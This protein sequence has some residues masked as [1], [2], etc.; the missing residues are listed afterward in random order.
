MMNTLSPGTACAPCK[1]SRV[2]EVIEHEHLPSARVDTSF[3]RAGI[4]NSIFSRSQGR[5]VTSNGQ[6]PRHK[7]NL[8]KGLYNWNQQNWLQRCNSDICFQKDLDG[9]IYFFDVTDKKDYGDESKSTNDAPRDEPAVLIKPVV[10]HSGEVV[11]II[12]SPKF[13]ISDQ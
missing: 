11:P 5:K 8:N 7:K 4:H 10:G 2:T 1:H 13:D 9:Q 3:R 6:K 12:G